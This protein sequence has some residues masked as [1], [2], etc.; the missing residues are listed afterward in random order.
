MIPLKALISYLYI[1]FSLLLNIQ[2]NKVSLD[3]IL[4]FVKIY[5]QST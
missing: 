2:I 4:I 1:I 5:R 3:I